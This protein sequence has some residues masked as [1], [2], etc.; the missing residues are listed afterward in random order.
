MQV[1]DSHKFKNEAT[2]RFHDYVYSFM[3]K[4]DAARDRVYAAFGLTEVKN[5]STFL[6]QLRSGHRSVTLDQIYIAKR[7]FDLN[8]GYLFETSDQE[9]LGFGSSIVEEPS[10]EYG[11]R[12]A[13]IQKEVGSK[14]EG[15]LRKHRVKI[16]PYANDRLGISKQALYD[17]MKGKTRQYFDEVLVICEDTGESLDQFRRTPLPKGHHLQ[18]MEMMQQMMDLLK[19]E[20]ASLKKQVKAKK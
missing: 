14:M 11:L 17:K 4:G 16:E 3:K 19:A 9:M 8:P 13:D 7:E 10:A 15:I 5:P 2:K 18:Q 6:G 1:T 20:N 12:D